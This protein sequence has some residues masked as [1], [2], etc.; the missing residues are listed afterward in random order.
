M[1]LV[2]SHPQLTREQILRAARHQFDAG[3]VLHWWHP[4]SGRGVRTCFSDD[5]VWLPYVTAFYVGATGD[6]AI[7]DEA[8][9]F[10][11]GEPL[12]PDE[13]E[14]YGNWEPAA[15]SHTLYEHCKRA[16]NRAST[17]GA[18]GLPLMGSG[19]WNDGM[20]RVGIHGR[21]ESVWMGWF[22][23]TA[24][25]AFAPLCEARGDAS[26]A[27]TYRLRMEEYRQALEANAWD[28]QWY[29]RAFYDD[30]TPLG[31][32][33]NAECRIDSLS[34][35]WA[36]ISK[37]ADKTRAR[38]GMESAMARLVD[39]SH[40]LLL[41]FEPPFD[42]TERDPGYIKGYVPGIRE[43]G[44]QYTHAAIWTVWA[45]TELGEG[46]RAGGL[47]SLLNPICHGSTPESIETY[48]VEPY[49]IAADV[50]SVAPHTGRGGWTWYTGSSGWMYRLGIEAILGLKREGDHLRIDPCIPSDW[51][52]FSATYRAN[53][54]VYNIR[55]ENPRQVSRGVTS[56][57]LDG[58]SVSDSRIPLT[59]ADG[60]F[61]REV[62][63]TLG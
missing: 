61:T 48:K 58:Q 50:Y 3:D 15:E 27:E 17:V 28:G 6:T 42:K 30:G 39:R 13:E 43:N 5:L 21:G 51:P 24:L 20:N 37:A 40:Q 2:H 36:V 63:V 12:K 1:A 18:H 41:L 59:T 8:V 26:L 7:L 29:L 14:R 47:F 19:D 62:V 23:Y 34:Q 56:L 46:D 55:V 45:F 57:T 22:L 16:L 44:G 54:T 38:Q 49:V 10:L 53:G 35:S 9:P 32:E 4:P 31:S 52:G 33:K 25:D 11:R 60:T